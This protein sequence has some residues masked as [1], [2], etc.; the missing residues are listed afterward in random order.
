[1]KGHIRK[2]GKNSW[3]IKVELP[4][5]PDGKRQIRYHS[6]KGTKREA[7]T[8]AAKLVSEIA[9]DT[10][11]DAGKMTVG[12]FL[13][14]WLEG[15]EGNVS[16]KTYDVQSYIVK[17][18][19]IPNIGALPLRKL[20]GKLGPQYVDEL[21]ARLRKEGRRNGNGGLSQRTVHH[22]HN[23]LRKALCRA[24]ARGLIARNPTDRGLIDSP[25]VERKE[26]QVLDPEQIG[27]LLRAAKDT[28][29][30]GPL[31]LA[32]TTGMRRG[33][34]LG[35]RWSDVDLDAGHL[36]VVQMLEKTTT[37][38]F[39]L[40]TPKTKCSQR[41]ITLPSVTVDVLR[42]HKVA[43]M[44]ERMMLGLGRAELLFTQPDGSYVN[45]YQY[46]HAFRAI[47]KRAGLKGTLH[48]LRHSHASQLLKDG[49]AVT[50]V[51]QR[52]GHS[53]PSITLSTY[54]H[55]MGGMEETAATRTDEALR[56]VIDA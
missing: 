17:L 19:L 43:Q 10:Y 50:T 8:K 46:T 47:A 48:G 51:A 30:Y 18:H 44:E 21:Y 2:R 41:R 35:L 33:E 28:R 39:R 14:K 54:A 31:V 16:D 42:H 20:G 3:E 45:P 37:G 24:V 36:T 9:D 22:C 23:I 53:D 49:V 34:V 6:F 25:R 13:E 5:G 27:K 52:L 56:G 12:E 40:K 29:W 38:G 26:V 32:A 55:L 11:A 7:E 1:M 4:R 15:I